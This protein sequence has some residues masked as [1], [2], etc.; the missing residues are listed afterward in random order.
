MGAI[1]TP[2]SPVLSGAPGF[3]SGASFFDQG[4]FF[5]TA[6]QLADDLLADDDSQ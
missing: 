1:G 5:S 4:S 2:V 6:D 3:G